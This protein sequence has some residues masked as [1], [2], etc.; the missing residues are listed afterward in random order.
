MHV[1]H[2]YNPSYLGGKDQEN[3]W[4]KPAWANSSQDP[5]LKITYKIKDWRSGSSGTA[6]V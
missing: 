6:P 4:L 5:I 3:R 2:A 1:V